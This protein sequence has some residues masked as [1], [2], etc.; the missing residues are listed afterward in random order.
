MHT[1]ICSNPNTLALL[2]NN[3]VIPTDNKLIL[4]A[5]ELEDVARASC[6]VGKVTH[7]ISDE[8]KTDDIIIVWNHGRM[9]STM[10]AGLDENGK[11]VLYNIGTTDKYNCLKADII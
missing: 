1:L 9:M 3:E 6:T 7:I 2:L 5:V 8:S 10:V 11:T 4:E